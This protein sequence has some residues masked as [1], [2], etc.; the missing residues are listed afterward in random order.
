MLFQPQ[1]GEDTGVTKWPEFAAVRAGF[2]PQPTGGS[3]TL[4]S[5]SAV[6]L[7]LSTAASVVSLSTVIS[8]RGGGRGV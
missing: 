3:V 7:S 6:P 8:L 5:L 4:G 1:G 2:K